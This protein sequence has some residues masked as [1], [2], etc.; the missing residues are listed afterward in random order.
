MNNIHEIRMREA[1]KMAQRAW[2]CSEVP[3]GAVAYI[4]NQL[5]AKAHNQVEMLNDCTAHAEMILLTSLMDRFQSKYLRGVSIYVTVEPCVMC[6]GAIK[7]AQI[8]ELYFG[9]KEPKY[10]YSIYG[11]LLHPKTKVYSGFLEHE[12]Q[13]LMK[14]FFK[15]KR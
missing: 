4:D 9:I 14:N 13:E 15:N 5:I 1:L 3:V 10:G 11:D 2:E 8:S 12:I 7:W 6:A